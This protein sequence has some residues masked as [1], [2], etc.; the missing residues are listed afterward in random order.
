MRLSGLVPTRQRSEIARPD[1][2]MF[3][4]LQREIDRLFEEFSRGIMPLHQTTANLLPTIDV[5]EADKEIEVTVE[6]PGL[7]RGDVE[8]FLEDNE[9]TIRGEK[10]IEA[11]RNKKNVYVGER[12]YGVFLRTI[13]LPAGIDPSSIDACMANGVLKICIPKPAIS[14]PKKI[15]VKESQQS[16]SQRPQTAPS[17]QAQTASQSA[18]SSPQQQT[19]G[20]AQRR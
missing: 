3:G 16:A 12:A 4:P 5:A 11:D 8:I 20:A 10:R 9:L 17:S 6:M 14:E 13:E 18:Q 19:A 1:V 2:M 15:E 7:E